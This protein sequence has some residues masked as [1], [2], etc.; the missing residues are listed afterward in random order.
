MARDAHSSRMITDPRVLAVLDE[1]YERERHIDWTDYTW[2]PDPHR[3][4]ETGFSLSPEQGDQL[5]LLARHGRASNVVEFATSLGFATIYL[6]AAVRDS[7]GGTVRTAELVPEKAERAR[8]NIERAGLG[9][10]VEFLVGDA[11]QTL[12]GVPDGVDLALIDGW[13]PEV[14]L[15]VLRV[16]EPRLRSGALIYNENLDASFIDHV[17]GEG[18]GYRSLTLLSGSE[19]KPKGELALRL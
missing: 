4:A 14:S 13:D 2:H 1:L 17:R 19:Y 11:R 7:G 16:I 3:H 6:A 10:Y 18:N 8:A 9:E 12:A 15:E 5:Y